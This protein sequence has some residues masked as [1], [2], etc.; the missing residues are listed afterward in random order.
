MHGG[1]TEH[2]DFDGRSI[3]REGAAGLRQPRRQDAAYR[4]A[5]EGRRGV[6]FVLLQQPVVRAVAILLAVWPPGLRNRRVRQRGG[7]SSA[8]A[9]LRTLSARPRLPHRLERQDA[10]L[11]CRS[12]ARLR[13]AT[14]DRYLPRGFRLDARLDS[15]RGAPELVSLD[16]VG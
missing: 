12:A 10:F 7:I 3:D 13:G 15:L 6:R 8:G 16:G 5:R 11:R 14:D 4:R 1:P 2:T 9:D